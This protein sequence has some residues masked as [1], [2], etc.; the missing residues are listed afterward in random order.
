MKKDQLQGLNVYHLKT[1]Y[2]P[3]ALNCGV[4]AMSQNFCLDLVGKVIA[5]K[6]FSEKLDGQ[7]VR[8]F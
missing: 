1:R 2:S 4:L 8:L 5:K 7:L 3:V 6:I